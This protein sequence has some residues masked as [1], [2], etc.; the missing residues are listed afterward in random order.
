MLKKYFSTDKG[1]SL[2]ELLV[3]ITIL[4]IASAAVAHSFI[5]ASR[6]TTDSRVFGEAT[7]AAD[8]IAE[9]VDAFSIE[10]FLS[11]KA[12][13]MLDIKSTENADNQFFKQ[14][15]N[16]AA[17]TGISSGNSKYDAIINYTNGDKESD[18]DSDEY[19]IYLL[20]NY[21]LAKY[22]KMDGSFTQSY[23]EAQNPDFKADAE[24]KKAA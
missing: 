14:N 16:R 5:T 4:G 19:G 2:V 20:N 23:K 24:F 18:V 17:I 13:Q 6:I 21:D 3:A 22:T 11:G 7:A 9:A 15:E 1:F 10:S 12:A 8:N